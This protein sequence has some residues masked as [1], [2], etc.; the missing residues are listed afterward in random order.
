MNKLTFSKM[1][2]L[3]NDFMVIDGT[4]HNFDPH[5]APIA[6]WADRHT[7]IGFDQLLLVEHTDKAD[8]DFRYRIFNA[9]GSE[10]QQCGN[11]ARCF[12]KFVAEQGLSDKHEIIVETAKGIIK[13]RL[14]DDGLVTV[15]MGQPRFQP[16]DLPFILRS[17]EQAGQL[18]Y[19]VVQDLDSAEMS[20]LSMGN[21]H[22]VMLVG[23]V[24][25]APV[26][27]WGAALQKHPRFPER[28]NVGFMEVLDKHN[29]KL[30]VY[31]RGAGETQA[32]G[33]G[34]CAAV[35]SGVRLGLLAAGEPVRVQLRGG[36]LHIIWS[37][38]EDVMMTGAAVKV[39]DGEIAY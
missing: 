3:G 31:E 21:P 15:N 4:R 34:A 11:G 17:N 1:H 30:R 32:C 2:G 6:A 22:A 29:I 20:L 7:G 9:D 26:A 23:D 13:P 12:V 25:T 28:V 27:D 16:E 36:D 19:I 14:N 5:T 35:V 24:E 33:T 10:V 18:T 8:V 38:G 37:E 39:F